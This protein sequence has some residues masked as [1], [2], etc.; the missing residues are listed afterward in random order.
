MTRCETGT[1]SVAVKG[2]DM[3]NV[4]V[5]L[6]A[7]L[8]DNAPPWT[9]EAISSAPYRDPLE[10]PRKIVM[11]P[12]CWCVVRISSVN[13]H[14]GPHSAQVWALSAL[15]SDQESEALLH[16]LQCLDQSES[17][18]NLHFR[19]RHVVAGHVAKMVLAR[20]SSGYLSD[21]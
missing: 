19:T 10:G 13:R 1:A 3:Q 21:M 6:A 4:A 11:N 16:S 14:R 17:L 9:V 2:I 8:V 12:V 20:L 15:S 18:G 5:R 7:P